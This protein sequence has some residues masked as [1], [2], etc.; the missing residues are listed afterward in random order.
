ME[1]VTGHRV[2]QSVVKDLTGWIVRGEPITV[3]DRSVGHDY[4]YVADIAGGICSV[5]DAPNP[6][7]FAYNVSAGRWVSLGTSWTP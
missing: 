1:R 5:L 7:Y 2:N 4:T 3:S 6:S